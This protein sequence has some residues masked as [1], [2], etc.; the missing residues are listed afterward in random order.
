MPS[1]DILKDPTSL[2]RSRRCWDAR[3]E[4]PRN[5][6]PQ[7]RDADPGLAGAVGVYWGEWSPCRPLRSAPSL[8]DPS[9]LTAP[10]AAL[11]RDREG[12]P[13]SRAGALWCAGPRRGRGSSGVLWAAAGFRVPSELLV[14]GYYRFSPGCPGWVLHG[15]RKDWLL[16]PLL[17]LPWRLREP[18]TA[19]PLQHLLG[20]T[21]T[22]CSRVLLS[23][24]QSPPRRRRRRGLSFSPGGPALLG[25]RAN[26]G[27]G[28]A[29]LARQGS[30]HL[31]LGSLARRLRA[32]GAAAASAVR[33]WRRGADAPRLLLAAF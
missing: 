25:P 15:S 17:S 16:C 19:E 3:E 10:W 12:F 33:S 13:K 7:R 18:G 20:M 21:R 27:S 24:L 23:R 2:A 11:C 28:R 14:G 32:G 8:Q 31:L 9:L 26:L 4:A 29:K 30:E 6:R 22:H 5:E 1:V